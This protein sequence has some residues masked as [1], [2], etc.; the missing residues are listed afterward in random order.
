MVHLVVVTSQSVHSAL[1]VIIEDC[2]PKLL[3]SL[4]T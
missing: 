4:D 3:P 1:C 2:E